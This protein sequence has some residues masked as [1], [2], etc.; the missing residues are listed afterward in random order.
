MS[1]GFGSQQPVV[2][3]T[4]MI[5]Q[6]GGDILKQLNK[7]ATESVARM[8]EA[9]FVNVFL[10]MF[11][12]DENQHRLASPGA[13]ASW[14]GNVYREVVVVDQGGKELFHV[15]ALAA[16]APIDY[17][18]DRRSKSMFDEIATAKLHTARHPEHGEAYMKQAFA[19]L[20]KSGYENT[21]VVNYLERWNAIFKRYGRPEVA[22]PKPSDSATA[23]ENATVEDEGSWDII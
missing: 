8:D 6:E 7:I 13:W 14:A 12:G 3:E 17:T 20:L 9:T 4:D 16:P 10:P 2:T 19:N 5:A 23:Q 21:V 1:T 11:A 18:R 22:I 15:P